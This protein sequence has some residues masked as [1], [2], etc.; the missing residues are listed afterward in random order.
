MNYIWSAMVVLSLVMGAVT[1]NVDGVLAAGLEGAGAAF[2]TVL[3][4]AGIMCF[5]S[6]ILALCEKGG[7]ANVIAKFLSPLLKKVF[8]KS[9]AMPHI[10]MNVTANLLGMG[11][12]ATPAGISA[13]QEL[14][15]ENR[16]RNTPNRAMSIFAVM[17]TASL[18][19]VPATVAAMRAKTGAAAPFDIMPAVW[20]TSAVSLISAVIVVL[21]LTRN[22]D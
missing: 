18:Q 10:A 12:A 3:G 14:D 8:G 16:G 22:Y 15:R 4:F 7:L 17:N 5:W 21:V 19:I 9:R 6:G 2:E 20:I 11:N 1:G 13:M